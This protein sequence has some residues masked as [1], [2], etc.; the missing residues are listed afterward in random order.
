MF[1]SLLF[2]FCYSFSLS[3]SFSF[4]LGFVIITLNRPD[5]SGLCRYFSNVILEDLDED[6]TPLASLLL[7]LPAAFD[8]TFSSGLFDDRY[9]ESTLP[10]CTVELPAD[11]S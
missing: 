4:S 10:L 7:P 8:E 2:C 1:F 5:D 11:F 6:L 3:L 9:R